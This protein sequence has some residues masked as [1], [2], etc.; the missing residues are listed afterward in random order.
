VLELESS[1]STEK[2]KS[3]MVLQWF[4]A[5]LCLS[6]SSNKHLKRQLSF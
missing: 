1:Y 3:Y 4:Y 2:L 6:S 5:I